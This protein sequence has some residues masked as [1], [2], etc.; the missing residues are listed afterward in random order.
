MSQARRSSIFNHRTPMPIAITKLSFRFTCQ[1][2]FCQNVAGHPTN[3][4]FA[5][6]SPICRLTPGRH[7]P[8]LS[9]MRWLSPSWPIHL[10]PQ[11]YKICADFNRN[12]WMNPSK[13]QVLRGWS[14]LVLFKSFNTW[15]ENVHSLLCLHLH[16]QDFNILGNK[17]SFVIR[18]NDHFKENFTHLAISM[19]KASN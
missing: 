13:N 18:A 1:I 8:A 6:V 16:E 3:F 7:Q 15:V 4:G 17:S 5:L 11:N 14:E 12:T 10:L 19:N 9:H 2:W